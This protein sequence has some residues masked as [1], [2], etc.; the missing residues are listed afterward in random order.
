MTSLEFKF[1]HYNIFVGLLI[2][3]GGLAPNPRYSRNTLG[4]IFNLEL[5]KSSSFLSLSRYHSLS[6]RYLRVKL[7][8]YHSQI[9]Q[10]DH[11]TAYLKMTS[12][13]S[14]VH[15]DRRVFGPDLKF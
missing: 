2:I 12:L 8:A 15:A 4:S 13:V 7:E 9:I 10:L 1:N 5:M 3:T 14:S 11:F 6:K